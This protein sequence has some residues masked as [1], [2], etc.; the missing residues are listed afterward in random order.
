MWVCHIQ[1]TP[2]WA[3]STS[4]LNRMYFSPYA[5]RI[6]YSKAKALRACRLR[7][8]APGHTDFLY[9]QV[10]LSTQVSQ[11]QQF[12]GR[13][14]DGPAGAAN[15][16]SQ[17]LWHYFFADDICGWAELWSAS[18]GA[19]LRQ[20]NVRNDASSSTVFLLYVSQY[21][22]FVISSMSVSF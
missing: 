22:Y 13:G 2:S 21:A 11:M 19:T 12:A 8:I 1:L 17:V 14:A 7:T 3:Q 10:K 6:I 9:L 4:T 16:H 15:T 20:D 5:G 18:R